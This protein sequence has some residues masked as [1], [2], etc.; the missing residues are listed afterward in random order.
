MSPTP[1]MLA[2]ALPWY[3]LLIS[4]TTATVAPTA[5]QPPPPSCCICNTAVPTAPPVPPTAA[6]LMPTIPPTASPSRFPTVPP[7]T[8]APTGHPWSP[9]A[10]PVLPPTK[11]PTRS[12]TYAP[13]RPPST[14]PTANPTTSAPSSPPTRNPTRHPTKSPL[15]PGAPTQNPMGTPSR[16]PT[17]FPSTPPTKHPT[18]VPSVPPSR[19]PSRS[20]TRTP[21]VS[22]SS[23]PT[24]SPSRNPTR[25][26]TRHPSTTP[27]RTPTS[28]PSRTPTM[29]PTWFP[30]YH[31]STPPTLYPTWH[32]YTSTPTKA[33]L[34]PGSPTQNPHSS[35]PSRSPRPWPTWHPTLYPTLH[36]TT[37]IPSVSPTVSPTKVPT[38]SP[39]ISPSTPPTV[40]PTLSPTR[41]PTR[42]PTISPT[43]SPSVS[44]SVPPSKS[45]SVSP[46]IPPT[47]HPSKNPT[48]SPTVSPTRSPTI[49]PTKNPTTTFPSAA[50]SIHPTVSPSLR[51]TKSPLAPDAPTESPWDPPSVSPTAHPTI[52]PTGNPTIS[53]TTSPINPT[54]SPS[55]TAPTQSPIPPITEP[56]SPCTCLCPTYSPT[57]HPTLSPTVP[58]STRNPTIPPTVGPT[59]SPVPPT[60]SPSQSPSI[61]PSTSS[62][63]VPPTTSAPSVSPTLAPLNPS[64][65]PTLSPTPGPTGSPSKNPTVSPT[66][67]PTTN[68]T[69]TPTLSPTVPPT[70][71]ITASPTAPSVSP[72]SPTSSPSI[73]TVL[74]EHIHALQGQ[75]LGGGGL[76]GGGSF[77]SIMGASASARSNGWLEVSLTVSGTL[78]T[79]DAGNFQ[80]GVARMLGIHANRV[81]GVSAKAGSLVVHFFVENE[82]PS[83]E[84]SKNPT[85]S[86]TLPTPPAP[87]PHPPPAPPPLPPS[88][89]GVCPI[90]FTA[91]RE[92][93]REVTI[94]EFN[95]PIKI[96]SW[97]G[98]KG[99]CPVAPEGSALNPSLECQLSPGK[100]TL[101]V[102]ASIAVANTFIELA[103]G[104][105]KP[106]G[107]D[108]GNNKCG[109]Y[110]A[111]VRALVAPPPPPPPPVLEVSGPSELACMALVEAAVRVGEPGYTLSWQIVD[112]VGNAKLDEEAT[113][114]AG[115][116]EITLRQAGL[117]D[118][119][120]IIVAA[121][122]CDSHEQCVTEQHTTEINTKD[123]VPSVVAVRPVR[124]SD[125]TEAH[126]YPI[127]FTY[128][129]GW[130]KGNPEVQWSLGGLPPG[131]NIVHSRSSLSVPAKYFSGL[132]PHKVTAFLPE[133]PR[134]VAAEFSVTPLTS[135]TAVTLKLD[136][137]GAVISS[138]DPISVIAEVRDPANFPE[139]SPEGTC[140]W[141][142]SCDRAEEGPV[143]CPQLTTT[144]RTL[145]IS[146]EHISLAAKPEDGITIAATCVGVTST[147][148]TVLLKPVPD[149]GESLPSGGAM[150]HN[151]GGT[152]TEV[153]AG[154]SLFMS[155]ILTGPE[156]EMMSIGGQ[157]QFNWSL[158]G[159]PGATALAD[160][161]QDNQVFPIPIEFVTSY[162]TITFAISSAVIP[163]DGKNEKTS[164]G[165]GYYGNHEASI[166]VLP[167]PLPPDGTP[168][169]TARD[170]ECPGAFILLEAP[171]WVSQNG[172][173]LSYWFS[174]TVDGGSPTLT[175][176]SATSQASFP[177]ENF[178]SPGSTVTV[179]YTVF[180]QDEKGS[181][182]TA[183]TTGTISPVEVSEAGL[184]TA[185]HSSISSP[186]PSTAAHY[187]KLTAV[188][189]MLK[190]IG[191][192]VTRSANP[193]IN[194]NLN[195]PPHSLKS[196]KLRN[197]IIEVLDGVLT[198]DEIGVP[199]ISASATGGSAV[200]L[201][202]S[203]SDSINKRRAEGMQSL[204]QMVQAILDRVDPTLREDLTKQDEG[205][206][207]AYAV[208]DTMAEQIETPS[209]VD[210]LSEVL[211]VFPAPATPEE[212]QQA[213]GALTGLS[214]GP[215]GE[216]IRKLPPAQGTT[217]M[218]AKS[219]AVL[220]PGAALPTPDKVRDST[221]M[222]LPT[223]PLPEG[224]A[225]AVLSVMETALTLENVTV[226]TTN[227]T[228]TPEELE[229]EKL[230]KVAVFEGANAVLET[231]GFCLLA[232]AATG[233]VKRAGLNK[234]KKGCVKTNPGFAFASGNG[235]VMLAADDDEFYYQNYPRELGYGAQLCATLWDGNPLDIGYGSSSRMSQYRWGINT[236]GGGKVVKTF[237]NLFKFAMNRTKYNLVGDADVKCAN[238]TYTCGTTDPGALVW[239]PDGRGWAEPAECQW[240]DF[241]AEGWSP[242]GCTYLGTNSTGF[243]QC[244]CTHLTD[245]AL[246]GAVPM[247][248]LPSFNINDFKISSIVVLCITAVTFIILSIL[249]ILSEQR[250]IRK[251]RGHLKDLRSGKY[252]ASG[253]ARPPV[254]RDGRNRELTTGR[255]DGIRELLL[256][257]ANQRAEALGYGAKGWLLNLMEKAPLAWHRGKRQ[258]LWSAVWVTSPDSSFTAL[259]GC[260]CLAALTFGTLLVNSLTFYPIF[261]GD[262]AEPTIFQTL[263]TTAGSFCLTVLWGLFIDRTVVALF[264]VSKGIGEEESAS[265]HLEEEVL[266]EMM[267]DHPRYDEEPTSECYSGSGDG[268]EQ[269]RIL[270]TQPDAEDALSGSG[271]R[272]SVAKMP[273]KSP[274]SQVFSDADYGERKVSFQPDTDDDQF[275]ADLP[276]PEEPVPDWM[277]TTSPT[278]LMDVTKRKSMEELLSKKHH[279]HHHH[280]DGP[281]EQALSHS[282]FR[283]SLL[284]ADYRSTKVPSKRKVAMEKK[285]RKQVELQLGEELPGGT[286]KFAKVY[287]GDQ[288]PFYEGHAPSREEWS[289]LGSQQLAPGRRASMNP[290]E[291]AKGA[292]VAEIPLDVLQSKS[293]QKF[294]RQ[295][296]INW[297]DVGIGYGTPAQEA[298]VAGVCALVAA[299]ST[300]RVSKDPLAQSNVSRG[301]SARDRDCNEFYQKVRRLLEEKNESAYTYPLD[302]LMDIVVEELSLGRAL[303]ALGLAIHVSLQESSA[304][305]SVPPDFLPDQ[306]DAAIRRAKLEEQDEGLDW[307]LERMF[308]D[309][310]LE[311]EIVLRMMDSEETR[312]CWLVGRELV[313]LKMLGSAAAVFET[314][315]AMFNPDIGEVI[316][317]GCKTMLDYVVKCCKKPLMGFTFVRHYMYKFMDVE[318]LQTCTSLGNDWAYVLFN[319]QLSAQKAE[320]RVLET[321]C[322]LG[323][324]DV[325][326]A[327]PVF[328][329]TSYC[330]EFEM[331][332]HSGS[333]WSEFEELLREGRV[334]EAAHLARRLP[335][336]L[337]RKSIRAGMELSLEKISLRT[338]E[339]GKYRQYEPVRP[340]LP[341]AIKWDKPNRC[342]EE[343][344]GF[345][346]FIKN[347]TMG[348]EDHTDDWYTTIEFN[349]MFAVCT[350][351]LMGMSHTDAL[352][353]LLH[354]DIQAIGHRKDGYLMSS[355]EGGM[356]EPD[357]NVSVAHNILDYLDA[358]PRPPNNSSPTGCVFLPN[359][360]L[361]KLIQKTQAS[362]VLHCAPDIP[363]E[364]G[365]KHSGAN[366]LESLPFST[367]G[368]YL[369]PQGGTGSKLNP[370]RGLH[371]AII[372]SRTGD[373]VE[374]EAGEYLPV[375]IEEASG[376][377]EVYT[378]GGVIQS[379][380]GFPAIGLLHCRSMV[381]R[382][383]ELYGGWN[384]KASKACGVVECS[385]RGE[386]G[387]GVHPYTSPEALDIIQGRNKLGARVPQGEHGIGYGYAVLA[388][389]LALVLLL[390]SI[391]LTLF[392]A[393]GYTEAES[394]E[395]SIRALIVLTLDALVWRPLFLGLKWTCA[396]GAAGQ[397]SWSSFDLTSIALSYTV[398][399]SV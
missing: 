283:H 351:E 395:W 100:K 274:T 340:D 275:G 142:V 251:E 278:N 352:F 148:V 320:H 314:C 172:G 375:G 85:L 262:R 140:T 230:Q 112:P 16:P 306:V 22:P 154:R 386:S 365:Y 326:P 347:C 133:Y 363:D 333:C 305:T 297:W 244:E 61:P 185:A 173:D 217:L 214:S 318:H 78:D 361:L 331:S 228:F 292:D 58:P 55:T 394:I 310:N 163:P 328:G 31:P 389:A 21:S 336:A 113:L 63:S 37:S 323:L 24:V 10:S 377:L 268:G 99:P 201:A 153:P 385:F 179:E 115:L 360:M 137:H 62:P 255:Y 399:S 2:A 243:I 199:I 32:P 271:R 52:P 198:P 371:A 184:A 289:R 162:T 30:T 307:A 196:K 240:W 51:P 261:T 308:P 269:M 73:T 327:N 219:I 151:R 273:A 216:S 177:C 208:Q 139:T 284:E 95:R 369:V 42:S 170:V 28:S 277:R 225:D 109:I 49:P 136:G 149:S 370:L 256:D 382:G 119:E 280:H 35:W 121:T 20:P 138:G 18:A 357:A 48:V 108:V 56:P 282:Q 150:L 302:K 205:K 40:S 46:T 90:T 130:N 141:E 362:D 234:L 349:R 258:H 250:R 296:H 74:P 321:I 104:L 332:G 25:P 187:A 245:F 167:A 69:T 344:P 118:G 213:A 358:L 384:S 281:K 288:D 188:A 76:S 319:A 387:W 98:L 252:E 325:H 316:Y 9:S 303:T 330:L 212:Q 189:G 313:A 279:H 345:R 11:N 57:T 364:P 44:P 226:N 218:A 295:Y 315:M 203:L 67:H 36:P 157:S 301:V 143:D 220:V 249:A 186:A 164:D 304:L 38:R 114:A 107:K 50:P 224:V 145:Q 339:G 132:G 335:K 312:A 294:L 355:K 207:A 356:D 169:I 223:S 380:E 147:P 125:L 182:A 341:Y 53:P 3:F 374:C 396:P 70:K 17:G 337:P 276:E 206:L 246:G 210:M 197:A 72:T 89:P 75:S 171:G 123:A 257:V 221:D 254:M 388:Y 15:P 329:G 398:L 60:V 272:R 343:I 287:G 353:R 124:G 379:K 194:L 155:L 378:N 120:K 117:R 211:D 65:S 359:P 106:L 381:F 110:E 122:V 235:G 227:I 202:L 322:F 242:D 160:A 126:S 34:I 88:P 5:W 390:G 39:S 152:A 366:V 263:L 338:K 131:A 376:P 348:R 229:A 181:R 59:L 29:S 158:Q 233:E 43:R 367:L 127:L 267:N 27:S 175:A 241:K 96:P 266:V 41:P 215:L 111:S 236:P 116:P 392:V 168:S 222:I 209:S 260:C 265:S 200:Q 4:T 93:L 94:I 259:R 324:T 264:R 285:R 77:G 178:F 204:S 311:Q 193:V 156:E 161:V 174:A 14:T 270:T 102:P 300:R 47:R 146:R 134:A 247:I 239:S 383:W 166:T 334:L 86:P 368:R 397:V 183:T 391:I 373:K 91:R 6:P 82:N 237:G 101:T 1:A 372:M 83:E 23:P 290:Y 79:F 298:I 354:D 84:P 105:A 232:D 317:P 80:Q 231:I 293:V 195:N 13:T 309:A 180:V 159:V 45:P 7:T 87:P 64:V 97:N 66:K 54:L 192:T 342:C 176:V 144:S 238:G 165:G 248:N 346:K 12:P 92:R 19:H 286:Y 103:G 350:A 68:P 129:C 71:G 291:A 393:G 26:P 135:L 299:S 191:G 128:P 253:V 8:G 190:S 81:S 33:P